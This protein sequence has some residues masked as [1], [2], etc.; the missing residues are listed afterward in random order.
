M[1]LRNKKTGAIGVLEATT[2]YGGRPDN[3]VEVYEI[4]MGAVRVL[5]RYNTLEELNDE[6]ED[7]DE[8]AEKE[9][10]AILKQL[11]EAIDRMT[12][13]I[14]KVCGNFTICGKGKK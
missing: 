2:Y 7:Y 8:A 1:K 10:I 11:S 14:T 3:C 4:G 13:N 5:A 6:W 9:F 12:A